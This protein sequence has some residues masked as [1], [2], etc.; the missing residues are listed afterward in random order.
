MA[1]AFS[2]E[3]RVAFEQMLEGFNDDLVMSRNVSVYNT[4]S[5]QMARANDTIWRPTPYIATSIDST[6]GTD[7]GSFTSA[8]QLSVPVSLGFNKTST[9]TLNAKELRDSLQEGRL[10]TAARQK[11]ASDINVAVQ[12]AAA[13]QGTLV[14]PISTAAGTYDD[15]A[16]AD[17]I[18]N[19]QGIMAGDRYLALSSRDYNGMAGNLATATRSLDNRKSLNAYERSQVGMVAGFDTYKLEYAYRLT[20]KA[21]TGITVNTTGA[22]V[23]YTPLA[24]SNSVGGKINVDN[25]YQQ[26]TVSA[27]TNVKA[28]DAFTID[29]VY[30]VH[31]ITKQ[32]TDNLKTF[33]VI[34]VDSGTTMTISPPIIGA[35]GSPTDP[36]KQYKNVEVS[37]TSAT[38][39]VN[40][41]NTQSAPVNSFWSKDAIQLLPGRLSVPTDAGVA[42][43]KA[44]TDQG[45]ELVMSKFFDIGSMTTKYRLDTLFGVGV[46]NPEMCGI[47][48]WGQS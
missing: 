16:R 29:G 40:W 15:V 10:G 37:A 12:N 34:S 28:G 47:I 32:S 5:T 43:M 33:R 1:N 26:I 48:M 8:T 39:A 11:L 13:L 9:W 14:V 2:R 31:H 18:M 27:T 46:V 6:P 30:A 36:Q 25:R 23:N 38:A 20:A 17:T 3:E 21:A 19:E 24:T 4:D 45:I 42:V 41:L 7:I 22:I 35:T 44:S